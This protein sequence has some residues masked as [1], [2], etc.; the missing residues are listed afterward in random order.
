LAVNTSFESNDQ[1][2]SKTCSLEAEIAGCKRQISETVKSAASL[3]NK[4]VEAKKLS[5]SLT[6]RLT[7]LEEKVGKL[8]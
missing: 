4:A 6:K 8:G 5:N 3:A 2:I 1:L 7:K